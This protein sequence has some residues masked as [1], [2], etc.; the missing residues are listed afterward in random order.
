MELLHKFQY[1]VLHLNESLGQVIATY[2]N[3]TYLILFAIIFCETGLVVTPFLPGDSLLFAA[4]AFAATVD[5]KTG[6]TALN[7]HWI[8][9][10]LSVA[11]ILGDAV[12]YSIG[13]FFGARLL[14]SKSPRIR[15][16]FK[17]EYVERTHKF[18]E[19]Y[20]KKAIILA[21]FV[22]IV[23]TFI[24]FMAGLGSMRYYEFAV[25]NV[26]GGILWVALMTMSGYFLGTNAW[27]QKHFEMVVLIIIFISIL[28]M[29]YEYW[30]HKREQAALASA[31]EAKPR[32][33]EKVNSDTGDK[34]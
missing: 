29:V 21:R 3:W 8:L 23:R 14:N 34:E 2:H 33:K 26:V 6:A 18:Y 7:L 11:A 30:A 31:P 19:K 13:H 32:Q 25:Y 20:G 12:N 16:I 5:A 28:P 10:L 15:K 27:I 22:P 4:G 1:F 17:P 9:I 24:P